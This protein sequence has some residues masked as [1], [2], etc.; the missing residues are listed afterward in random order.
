MKKNIIILFLFS[1]LVFSTSF[2]FL[3]SIELS[4]CKE[5]EP[6][7][8]Y[9]FT[10]I[11]NILFYGMGALTLVFFV[12]LFVPSGFSIWKKFATWFV[13]ISILI[14]IFY[15]EPRSGDL[16]SPYPEQIYI[17]ISMLYVIVSLVLIGMH[18][19]RNRR[20]IK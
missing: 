5:S 19:V 4:L 8:I 10:K 1:V 18:F 17:W 6:S 15:P 14:F 13:P 11:G 12:L 9:N 16:F 2:I 3:N 20:M 7:C